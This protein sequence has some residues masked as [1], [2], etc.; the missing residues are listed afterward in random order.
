MCYVPGESGIVFKGKI[1][2]GEGIAETVAIKTLK[3]G[4]IMQCLRYCL[5]GMCVQ[6]HVYRQNFN[7]NFTSVDVNCVGLPYI[8]TKNMQ[9]HL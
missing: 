6:C 2:I 4:Y 9:S 7:S 3:G 5:P 8:Y 1:V